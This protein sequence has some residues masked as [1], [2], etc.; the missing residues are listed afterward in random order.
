V[1]QNGDED[2]TWL[3]FIFSIIPNFLYLVPLAAWESQLFT[4]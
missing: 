3:H 1:E 2:V 4:I